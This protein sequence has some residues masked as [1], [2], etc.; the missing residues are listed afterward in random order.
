MVAAVTFIFAALAI[1]MQAIARDLAHRGAFTCDF[2]LFVNPNAPFDAQAG[3]ID[4]DRQLMSS[5]D[6]ARGF[7]HKV[8]PIMVDP[9]TAKTYGGGRYLFDQWMQARAYE[10]FVKEDFYT[11]DPGTG[12]IVQFLDRSVFANPDCRS[13]YVIGAT[14]FSDFRTTHHHLRT[15]RWSIP[16]SLGIIVLLEWKWPQVRAAAMRIPGVSAVW[17]LV[18][19]ED[20]VVSVVYFQNRLA[21]FSG[22]GL[23]ELMSAPSVLARYAETYG[24]SQVYLAGHFSLNIWLPFEPGDQGPAALWPNADAI[25]LT[26]STNDAVCSPSRGETSANDTACLAT[27]GNAIADGGESWLNCPAD[28]SPY[29][30]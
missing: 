12:Q 28:V 30:D 1:P 27:C 4:H 21:P 5:A 11:F 23:D 10:R 18:N 9:A 7:K 17:L 2:E 16:T 15:E 13:W 22:A 8:I 20:R 26:P 14:E 29:R 24:W 25:P 6:A 19:R 3:V